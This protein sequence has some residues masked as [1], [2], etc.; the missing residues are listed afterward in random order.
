M[1]LFFLTFVFLIS[2]L[3]GCSTTSPEE[4]AIHVATTAKEV[5]YNVTNPNEIKNAEQIMKRI[6]ALKPYYTEKA[7]SSLVANR[8][9]MLSVD[10]ALQQQAYLSVRS[11]SF[12]N[13]TEEGKADVLTFHYTVTIHMRYV[14]GRA[15]KDVQVNGQMDLIQEDGTWKIA[16]DWNDGTLAK[17]SLP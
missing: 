8:D 3:T 14:D 17:E 4:A 10:V 13:E 16:R 9:P 5:Q 7:L 11:I 1:K 15:S 12:S 2:L 6:D